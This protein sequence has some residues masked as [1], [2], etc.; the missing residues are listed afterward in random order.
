S[1]FTPFQ[2]NTSLTSLKQCNQFLAHFND[3]N[4]ASAGIVFEAGGGSLSHF[5]RPENSSLVTLD[6]LATQ[7][8]SHQ[9]ATHRIQG[10][11]HRIPLQQNS[12]QQ[13]IC[14]NVIEH[15]DDPDAALEE[16][17]QVL[18]PGGILVLGF[19]DRN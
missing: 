16:M 1:A 19:P 5:V 7:L 15:L 11:L 14:F 12:V 9:T 10:D 13:V 6:I 18:A 3:T 2:V 4:V 17:W 8:A